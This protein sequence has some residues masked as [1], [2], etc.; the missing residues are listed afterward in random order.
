MTVWLGLV[1]IKA[2]KANVGFIGDALGAYFS[3]AA[4]VPS[5]GDFRRLIADEMLQRGLLL[6]SVEDL[7]TADL[8]L[9]DRPHIDWKPLIEAA[10]QS[11][12][13]AIGQ[14]VFFYETDDVTDER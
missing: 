5:E 7:I 12:G 8:A 11:T 3:V 4:E 9:R 13:L 6:D 14:D 1:S 2:S 10:T